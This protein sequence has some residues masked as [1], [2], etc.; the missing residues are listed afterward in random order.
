MCVCVCVCVA[1]PYMGVR[2]HLSFFSNIFPIARSH[3]T[4]NWKEYCDKLF[5]RKG[6]VTK[7]AD[8]YANS[9]NRGTLDYEKRCFA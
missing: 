7:M 6:R 4:D 5:K 2:L 3:T 9:Q 8:I 1:E